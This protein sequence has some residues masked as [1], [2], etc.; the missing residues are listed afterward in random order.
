MFAQ[1]FPPKTEIILR[2]TA[3]T[4]SASPAKVANSHEYDTNMIAQP[5]DGT[6]ADENDPRSANFAKSAPQGN[7]D[8]RQLLSG[9]SHRCRNT[10]NGIK[11]GLYLFRR[12]TGGF[13]SSYV[14]ELDRNYQQVECLLDHL[15]AIYRPL[16]LTM[17]CGSLGHLLEERVAGWRSLSPAKSRVL[18]L[19]P[20]DQEIVGEFDPIQMG[21]GLDALARWRS[22][23]A[24]SSTITRIS[25]RL[26][27]GMFEICWEETPAESCGAIP[28]PTGRGGTSGPSMT[29]RSE[30]LAEPFLARI[31]AAHGGRLE[32]SLGPILRW[33]MLWPQFH[34]D[35]DRRS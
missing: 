6:A 35:A 9:F 14:S 18:G 20:P 2:R 4:L 12:E 13:A 23:A 31:L 10:L 11:M 19:V 15:Q 16:N 3:P 34:C 26:R 8:L 1:G 32:K 33:W 28:A 21:K 30:S 17:V 25:W 5:H 29:R 7:D 27:D 22:E 24:E